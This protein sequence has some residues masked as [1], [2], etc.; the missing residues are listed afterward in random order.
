MRRWVFVGENGGGIVFSVIT[1]GRRE[2]EGE[3]MKKLMRIIELV[4]GGFFLIVVNVHKVFLLIDP[5]QGP[6]LGSKCPLFFDFSNILE[7]DVR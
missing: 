1:T 2:V 4:D 3:V 7:F 6:L 5:L